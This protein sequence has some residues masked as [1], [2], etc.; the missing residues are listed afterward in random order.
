MI[1]SWYGGSGMPAALFNDTYVPA[2]WS[3]G[4]TIAGTTFSDTALYQNVVEPYCRTCHILRGTNNQNDIDF[5]TFGTPAAGVNPATGFLSYADRIKVHVFDRGNMP[6]AQIPHSD[7][8]NSS[9]P[10]M[11][12]SFVDAQLGAGTATLNGT[13]LMPGRPIADPGPNRMVKT[14]AN[15]VLT[16]ENSLFTSTYSW[17]S[18]SGPSNPVISNATGMVAIFNA[19][20]AGA[21]VVNLSVNGGASSKNLTVTVDDNF[22]DPLNIKFAH[23]KNVMQ[24]IQH[25]TAQTSG[26]CISCHVSPAVS[27]TPPIFYNST[28]DRDHSGGA[29]DATDEAWFLKAVQGRVNLTEITASPLLRKPS[30]NHHKGLMLLDVAD[31]TSN[32]GLRNYS[33]LYN[34]IL[35][36][37]SRGRRG[38]CARQWRRKPDHAH[39]HGSSSVCNRHRPRRHRKYRSDELLLV[40]DGTER[41]DRGAC[42]RYQP[43]IGHDHPERAGRRPVRRQSVRQRRDLERNGTANDHGERLQVATSHRARSVRP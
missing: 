12:A 13:P 34:W 6:L 40:G 41:P 38:E 11:L 4:A 31:T 25:S 23:V 20:V 9:A 24:N 28:L 3:T 10:Q 2:G 27:P 15:A 26:K 16:G 1:E 35:A 21:Y 32:G 22:P 17:T 29:A 14:G 37:C 19:S 39:L 18:V 7:F 43:D 42:I 30:G 36:G 8:W 5:M 33:I